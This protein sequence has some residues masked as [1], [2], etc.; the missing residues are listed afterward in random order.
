MSITV[1]S[2]DKGMGKTTFVR[3]CAERAAERGRRVG[4]IAAPAVFEDGSRVGYD[5]LDVGAGTQRP[6]ARLAATSAAQSG[7]KSCGHRCGV[8]EFDIEALNK[9]SNAVI[10][11]IRYPCDVV[12]IDEVGPLEF[13]GCGWASALQ[14]ALNECGIR[15]KLVIAVRPAL[16]DELP[17]RF[18]S[19]LWS[20]ARVTSPPWPDEF[21]S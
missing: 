11:A 20:E 3:R 9:G 19:P 14:I 10:A 13:R 6:L 4:G 18:P 12:V 1:V 5:L 17:D 2:A 7:P 8:Y 16:V 21:N 15:Q